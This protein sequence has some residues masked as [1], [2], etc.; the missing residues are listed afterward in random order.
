MK[1][2]NGWDMAYQNI[3]FSVQKPI[4]G[5][6][7]YLVYSGTIFFYIIRFVKF[8]FDETELVQKVQPAKIYK[9]VNY[10]F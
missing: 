7:I 10:T 2:Y 9:P 3:V 1:K 5:S 6:E 4:L 8:K